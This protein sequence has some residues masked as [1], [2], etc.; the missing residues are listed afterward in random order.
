MLSIGKNV[1]FDESVEQYEVHIHQPYASS[2]FN[3]ND[4]IRIAVQNQDSYILP[5]KSSL[6]I[7]G[8]ITGTTV[9]NNVENTTLVNNAI[10]HM[11]EEMRYELNAVEIEKIKNVGITTTMKAYISQSYG[12]EELLENGFLMTTIGL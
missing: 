6:H 2:T 12:Q 7:Q 3:N 10:C 9:A 11:F 5:C 4:E 1:I 8:R